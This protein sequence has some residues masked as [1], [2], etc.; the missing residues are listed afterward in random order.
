MS[1]VTLSFSVEFLVDGRC[2]IDCRDLALADL[3]VGS[4]SAIATTLETVAR[5]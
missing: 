5:P 3:L 2:A 4:E 1:V